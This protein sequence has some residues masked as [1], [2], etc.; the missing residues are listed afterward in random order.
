M[1]RLQS[2]LSSLLSSLL[3]SLLPSLIGILLLLASGWVM[4][5][6][7]Q[8]YPLPELWQTFTRIPNAQVWIAIGLTLLALLGF[9][10]YDTL[11]LRYVRHPL[12][13][14]KTALVAII[15]TAIS[16]SVGLALLSSSAIRY[17]FYAP[18]GL[19]TLQIT[20]VIAFCN[21]SFWLGLLGVGGTL[22]VGQPIAIPAMLHLPFPDTRPLGVAFLS[23]IFGYVFV[24]LIQGRSLRLHTW[25]IPHVPVGLCLAQIAVS[26]LDWGLAAAAFYS[27]LPPLASLS[28]S[29]F[30]A[31]YLLAQFAGVVSNVPGGLGVFETVMLLLLRPMFPPKILF[32]ALLAYR[33]IYYWLPFGLAVLLL[34]GYEVRHR[35]QA[36]R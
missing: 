17:R 30:F 5:Q 25:V 10:G 14:P 27:L 8:Q 9:T 16:N 6:E 29:A 7:F 15:S 34:A 2:L 26:A 36:R 24:N 28:Y 12:P 21:L 20:Q 33:V 11:A 31:I 22:F 1:Q 13:Y 19:S 18:W 32:G 4:V 3:P 35:W 23:M